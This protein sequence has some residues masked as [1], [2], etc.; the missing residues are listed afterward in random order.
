MFAVKFNID[1]AHNGLLPVTIGAT[2]GF[3]STN[4][5]G[6]TILDTQPL[7]VTVKLL[8]VPAVKFEIVSVPV[9]FVLPVVFCGIELFVKLTL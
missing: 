1:P 7:I 3:G 4:I 2:G 6:P 8:Y 5:N 9:P